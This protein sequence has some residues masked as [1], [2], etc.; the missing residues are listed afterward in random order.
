MIIGSLRILQSNEASAVTRLRHA[1]DRS[2]IGNAEVNS[3]LRPPGLPK[4]FGF[5]LGKQDGTSGAA[6]ETAAEEFDDRSDVNKPIPSVF[7]LQQLLEHAW[8]LGYDPEGASIFR[9]DGGVLDTTR[10]IGKHP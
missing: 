9:P 8:S 5:N 4:H 10:W 6:L 1:T 2:G 7:E 3:L